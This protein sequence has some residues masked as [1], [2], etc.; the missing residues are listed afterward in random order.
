MKKL[1]QNDIPIMQQ[2][3]SAILEV[4]PNA[5]IILYGSRAR[6]DN[7]PDSDLDIL[8]LVDK[9]VDYQL[10]Q[11]IRYRLYDV[12]LQEKMIISC[13]VHNKSLWESEKYRVL[14]LKKSIEKEGM[15]L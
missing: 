10:V 15:I 7:G 2:C 1:N 13:I 11:R 12:E 9:S 8:V 5:T 4:A 14:P 3:K 6:G